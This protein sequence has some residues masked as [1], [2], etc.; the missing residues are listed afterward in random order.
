MLNVKNAAWQINFRLCKKL[1][2]TM[3]TLHRHFIK[4]RVFHNWQDTAYFLKM[5]WHS[6]QSG[7]CKKGRKKLGCWRQQV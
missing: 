7:P 5:V 2:K 4:K 1:C 6:R 3:L